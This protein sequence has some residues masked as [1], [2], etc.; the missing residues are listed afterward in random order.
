MKK[1]LTLLAKELTFYECSAVDRLFA[2]AKLFLPRFVT[3]INNGKARIRL[4]ARPAR[5]QFDRKHEKPA[6]ASKKAIVLS[7]RCV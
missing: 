7:L 6:P 2:V 4:V 5:E 1:V 3:S